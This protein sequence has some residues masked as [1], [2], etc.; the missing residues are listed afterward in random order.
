MQ[1]ENAC[2]AAAE[3]IGFINATESGTPGACI[4]WQESGNVT[5][6]DMDEAFSSM[7]MDSL[8]TRCKSCLDPSTS[9]EHAPGISCY[10]A[11][12]SAEVS[13][14]AQCHQNCPEVDSWACNIFWD[15]P[16]SELE[17]STEALLALSRDVTVP[18][19]ARSLS[20]TDKAEG[21][22]A[23][24]GVLSQVSS[25]QNRSLL[26][27]RDGRARR[28]SRCWGSVVDSAIC[29]FKTVEDG[30]ICGWN[31]GKKCKYGRRRRW[32]G[33]KGCDFWKTAKNCKIAASCDVSLDVPSCLGDL[34]QEVGNPYREYAEYISNTGC[35]SVSSCKSSVEDGLADVWELVYSSTQ[36]GVLNLM[37]RGTE[38]FGDV[39][40]P[41]PSRMPAASWTAWTRLP[42]R[43]ENSSTVS[44]AAFRSMT[45]GRSVHRQMWGFGI[46][47]P[48]TVAS[49]RSSGTSSQA[50]LLQTSTG[51]MR[52][53]GSVRAR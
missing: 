41:G 26:S 12:A 7:V 4:L 14:Y 2:T 53:T 27:F 13:F 31:E 28:S 15:T 43:F 22:D 44:S 36:S 25:V 24:S 20:P 8:A 45:S 30:A 1:P 17:N 46:M 3:D 18:K 29:G 52:W 49:S 39:V 33:F 11:V 51:V 37:R 42:W 6:Q 47:F 34:F 23:L 9:C 35:S 19:S 21:R 40:S 50:P 48:R 32:S 16:D 5:L 38:Q 10:Q